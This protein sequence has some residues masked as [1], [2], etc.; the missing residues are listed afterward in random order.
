[1][2]EKIA[3]KVL[4]DFRRIERVT[5]KVIKPDPPIPGHYQSVA[6][7]ITEEQIKDEK[8]AYLSAWEQTWATDIKTLI[9]AIER[10]D[11]HPAIEL[12][13]VSSVYETDPVGY[14]EQDHF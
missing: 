4:S 2:A 5:V 12:V 11:G 7:E 3:A 14:E 9:K 10:L 8:T 13:N 1:M 6:I